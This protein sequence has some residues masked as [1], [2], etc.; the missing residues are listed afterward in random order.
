MSSIHVRDAGEFDRPV[1]EDILKA[2]FDA[3]YAGFMPAPFVQACRDE[4][5]AAQAVCRRGDS[6]AVAEIMGRVVGFATYQDNFINELWVE[7]DFMRQGV[8]TAL[9]E[10]VEERM[11]LKRMA[12]MTLYCFELNRGGL[13]FYQHLGFRKLNAMPSRDVEGGPVIVLTLA[14]KIKKRKP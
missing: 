7:P 1:M 10:Y 6:A 2:A 3:T 11:R 12:T 13:A 4:N 9:L 14:R 8:G 5:R